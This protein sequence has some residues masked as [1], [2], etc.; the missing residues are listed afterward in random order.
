MFKKVLATCLAGAMAVSLAA[1]GS[2]SPETQA[3]AT[4]AAAAQEQESAEASGD[5]GGGQRGCDHR[6]G[7]L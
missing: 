6:K 7:G 1:C 2:S 4:T 5:T 3:P